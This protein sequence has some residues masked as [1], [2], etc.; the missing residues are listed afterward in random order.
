MPTGL[1]GLLTF[2]AD[3]A[4]PTVV[5]RLGDIFVLWPISKNELLRNSLK[6]INVFIKE[7]KKALRYLRAFFV[8][9]QSF[10]IKKN[11]LVDPFFRKFLIEDLIPHFN[12]FLGGLFSRQDSFH[13]K[14]SYK[15]TSSMRNTLNK[16]HDL[17]F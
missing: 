14:T 9:F 1:E 16:V 15:P 12:L 6:V 10:F 2:P 4:L 3:R 8:L 13:S 7:T 11:R 5:P 17:P